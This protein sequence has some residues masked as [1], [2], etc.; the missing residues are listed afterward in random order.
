VELRHPEFEYDIPTQSIHD[1]GDDDENYSKGFAFS[2]FFNSSVSAASDTTNPVA[3]NITFARATTPHI[4]VGDTNPLPSHLSQ[5]I[6]FT[7]G[8]AFDA[9]DGFAS[10]RNPGPMNPIS[11]L[12]TP[13]PSAKRAR[14][15][16]TPGPSSLP[17]TQN[18]FVTPIRPSSSA[19]PPSTIRRTVGGTARKTGSTRTVSEV[20]ALKQLGDC[21]RASAR[22]K[23]HE[24]AGRTP[25]P[26]VAFGS[27]GGRTGVDTGST[28]RKSWGRVTLD[29]ERMGD[30]PG[31]GGVAD[32]S[33][34]GA[35][36]MRIF[37]KERTPRSEQSHRRRSYIETRRS[38][39]PD[40]RHESEEGN[41]ST[42]AV[43]FGAVHRGTSQQTE[44]LD[45]LDLPSTDD[46]PPASPS[47]SPRPTSAMSRPISALSR[48]VSELSR[49]GITPVF[50]S[51]HPSSTSISG[52]GPS[53]A[54]TSN[55]KPNARPISFH[56]ASNPSFS[57]SAPWPAKP[58]PTESIFKPTSLPVSASLHPIPKVQTCIF[59][60][61]ENPPR[62][63]EDNDATPRAPAKRHPSSAPPIFIPP[64]PVI[65]T[66]NVNSS[67]LL[68][69]PPI[70]RDFIRPDRPTIDTASHKFDA[71]NA[72]QRLRTLGH[73]MGEVDAN[74]RRDVEVDKYN[75]MEERLRTLVSDL[76]KVES[77]LK[78]VK[79]R[80]NV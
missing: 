5:Y 22:K 15:S 4:P 64:A 58:S 75:E 77:G 17:T 2:A 67:S 44:I 57:S 21:V 56:R 1:D 25:G 74:G 50:S 13:I 23:M 68:G 52:T 26:G 27:T 59:R 35:G 51:F 76:D 70:T 40:G 53:G 3:A 7:W 31:P 72:G 69:N 49:R 6:G 28:R 38:P 29:F 39:S 16:Q 41:D 61:T 20:E 79:T 73:V 33:V 71:E 19:Y 8:P 62:G 30:T 10:P 54:S 18:K 63:V 36:G 37:V 47:P 66:A 48:P 14:F 45:G 60:P 34:V 42:G 11:N 80:M 65:N 46:E 9:F 55:K 43:L 78:A 24:Y 32:K 12:Q